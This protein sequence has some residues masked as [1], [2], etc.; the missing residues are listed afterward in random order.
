MARFIRKRGLILKKRTFTISIT[1]CELTTAM[2]EQRALSRLFTL[3]HHLSLFLSHCRR[4]KGWNYIHL[5]STAKPRNSCTFW[6]SEATCVDYQLALRLAA[7]VVL[8]MSIPGF[9][10]HHQTNY[11]DGQRVAD[12]SLILYPIARYPRWRLSHIRTS[13]G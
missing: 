8:S 4:L 9:N 3:T 5:A 1:Q 2:A 13:A 12:Y 7:C 6:H 10:A 11:R